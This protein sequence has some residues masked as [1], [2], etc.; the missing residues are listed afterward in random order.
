MHPFFPWKP[1]PFI[2]FLLLFPPSH[3]QSSYASSHDF[4]TNGVLHYVCQDTSLQN[5][6]WSSQYSYY[7][8]HL[9]YS[10]NRTDFIQI[11]FCILTIA[12]VF[13]KLYIYKTVLLKYTR[14]FFISVKCIFG[15][16][17]N[18]TVT[19]HIYLLERNETWASR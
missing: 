6:F 2:S 5:A 3:C 19:L 17:W 1:I 9:R 15:R 16:S 12:M 13:N 10:T 11:F 7:R 8:Y 18:F 14:L 4:W